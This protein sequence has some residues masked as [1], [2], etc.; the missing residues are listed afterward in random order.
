MASAKTKDNTETIEE[1]DIPLLATHTADW[2]VKV[3]RA[4]LTPAE[5]QILMMV[6]T[7]PKGFTA[8]ATQEPSY[9]FI[10]QLIH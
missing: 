4:L 9:R 6:L 8:I 10:Y 2:G 1:D 7:S 3:A 5:L